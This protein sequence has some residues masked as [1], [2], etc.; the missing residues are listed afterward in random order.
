MI[1]QPQFIENNNRDFF[2]KIHDSQCIIASHENKTTSKQTHNKQTTNR[3][4]T[5]NENILSLVVLLITLAGQENLQFFCYS[6]TFCMTYD[7]LAV[8]LIVSYDIWLFGGITYCFIFSSISATETAYPST[9]L[10]VH[11]RFLVCTCCS[12]FS[13]VCS[14]L[15]PLIV[16][17]SFLLFTIVLSEL[18]LFTSSD[19]PHWYLRFTASD[20]PF[21]YLRFTASDYHFDILDLQLLTIH[22]DILDLQLLTIT[23]I[24]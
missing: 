5:R 22:F 17:L 21:W 8:L 11:I 13:F 1:K 6:D 9:V 4:T 24:S 10:W 15:S 14:V 16:F 7:H 3:P 2:S 19:Y 12:I 18:L 20:Y 23:L